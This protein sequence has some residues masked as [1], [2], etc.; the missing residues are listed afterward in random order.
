MP[1]LCPC[2]KGAAFNFAG[3]RRELLFCRQGRPLSRRG[4]GSELAFCAAAPL[5][6][7]LR[8]AVLQFY[9]RNMPP[10]FR[11]QRSARFFHCLSYA[12]MLLHRSFFV[13]LPSAPKRFARRIAPPSGRRRSLICFI[14][15]FCG[16]MP[17]RATKLKRKNW[18]S[19][20]NR[21]FSAIAKQGS[22]LAVMS[23][24]IVGV[25]ALFTLSLIH[26]SS[27]HHPFQRGPVHDADAVLA[28]A[29]PRRPFQHGGDQLPGLSLIH[30]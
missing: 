7:I 27:G 19:A 20:G 12:G 13:H 14:P 17:M 21:F 30:I 8:I 25:S 18:M 1:L 26:I 10:R 28:D 2:C 16:R 24:V 4:C 22:K 5:P 29:E 3:L 11:I 6:P 9:Q 15:C 23:A